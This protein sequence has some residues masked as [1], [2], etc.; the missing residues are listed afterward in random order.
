NVDAKVDYWIPDRP[1]PS[2]L[3]RPDWNIIG[4][5]RPGATL[6]EA[7]AELTAMTTRQVRDERD[8][9]GIMPRLQLLE[10]QMNRAGRRLLMPVAGA[11]A[12]VFLIG[13]GSAAGLLVAWGL[14]PP[15]ARTAPPACAARPRL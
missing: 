11:V 8:F 3:K 10:A 4:R 9:E 13:C 15:H 12:P 7:Q 1:A 6:N 5:L 2:R 14:P